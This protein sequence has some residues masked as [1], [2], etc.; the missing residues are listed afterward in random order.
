[1]TVGRGYNSG[2]AGFSFNPPFPGFAYDKETVWNY[3]GF[4]RSSAFP[5][6]SDW[7]AALVCW[8]RC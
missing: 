2:G 4:V 3:E 7:Q 6:S 1:V 8:P 5:C